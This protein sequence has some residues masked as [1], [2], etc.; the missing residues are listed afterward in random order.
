MAQ[1]FAHQNYD[2]CRKLVLAATSPGA[3]MVPGNPRV[4]WKIATARRYIDKG[5][6]RRAAPEIYGGAFRV[7][8]Q[9]IEAKRSQ[10]AV[11][12][13]RKVA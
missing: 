1:Q 3:L 7:N 4:L 13:K 6:M 2:M 10:N 11:G 5:F 9:L 8:P 12:G